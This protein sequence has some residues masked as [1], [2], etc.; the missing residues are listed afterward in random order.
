MDADAGVDEDVEAVHV[1][2]PPVVLDGYA[3]DALGDDAATARGDGAGDGPST[4]G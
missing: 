4:G 1:V 3:D 2:V